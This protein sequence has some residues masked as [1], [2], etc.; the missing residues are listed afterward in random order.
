MNA[1]LILLVFV[2]AIGVV[3]LTDVVTAL[4]IFSLIASAVVIYRCFADGAL[5]L[6]IKPRDA[7]TA[8]P[9]EV[10]PPVVRESYQDFPPDAYYGRDF[11]RFRSFKAT[12]NSAY[13]PAGYAGGHRGVDD[14]GM[15][16]GIARARDRQCIDGAVTK[17]ANYYKYHYGDELSDYESRPWWGR[18]E[19]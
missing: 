6:Q 4:Q 14:M 12:Y 11:D 10:A 19:W 8:P 16:L 15:K 1:V 9:R 3:I 2:I 18:N 13:T 7:A 5:D 17:N